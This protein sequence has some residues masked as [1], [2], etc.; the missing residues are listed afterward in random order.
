M[1][2]GMVMVA[3]AA[4][5]GLVACGG[6]TPTT[7]SSPVIDVGATNFVT[8]PPV[9]ATEPPITTAPDAPGSIWEF[10][11]EYTL[12]EG[13]LPSTVAAKFKVNFQQFLDLNGFV[14]EGQYVPLWPAP[15][16]IVKIPP[17]A[18]VPGEPVATVATTVAPG[19][20]T[21]EAPT[22]AT[23]ATTEAPVTATTLGGDCAPGSYTIEETDTSRQKVA[24]KFDVSVAALDAANA[25]TNGYSSFYAGLKI[26][27]PAPSDC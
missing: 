18:T 23:T 14:L 26:V 22:E 10:E 3:A 17:G 8:I 13:D 4:S 12:V 7:S 1:L 9:P 15:G 19:T 16:T 20:A 11:S 6:D 25:N 2:V 5:L 21:T 24:D 27:I